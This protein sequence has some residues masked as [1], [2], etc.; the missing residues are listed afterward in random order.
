MTEIR[1][2]KTKMYTRFGH[3][4]IENWSLFGICDLVLGIFVENTYSHVKAQSI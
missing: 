3:L 1:I 2:T 4:V